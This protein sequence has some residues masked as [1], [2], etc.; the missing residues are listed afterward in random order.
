[1]PSGS[2]HNPHARRHKAPLNRYALA[3]GLGWAGLRV[4]AGLLTGLLL[5]SGLLCA[6]PGVAWAGGAPVWSTEVAAQATDHADTTDGEPAAADSDAGW[7][8]PWGG[9]LGLPEPLRS[10]MPGSNPSM[11]Q[12]FAAGRDVSKTWQTM[13]EVPVG[14]SP[15]TDPGAHIV[16][17][18]GLNWVT[19]FQPLNR[20]YFGR[21]FGYARM[22]WEPGGQLDTTEVVQWDWT[23]I[24]NIAV[25]PWWVISF[26][27]GLGFMDGLIFY[28]D[29][30]FKHRLEPFIP[31]QVGTG[32][33]IGK[34]IFVGAKLAQSS[35][36]GPGP[37]AS[38][39]RAL[40]GVGYNY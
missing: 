21:S 4:P 10:Q 28:K 39:S 18:E 19:S 11:F 22:V 17:N 13:F 3:Q 12:R 15:Q 36:F 5:C 31:L 29:G 9:E 16:A 26:G 30:S 25:R 7:R 33:R 34:S 23:E 27:V 32:V 6:R 2:L 14:L 38:A 40:V 8:L 1:M 37:V 20:V 35:Y 24:L